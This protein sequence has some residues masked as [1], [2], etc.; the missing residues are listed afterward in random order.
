MELCTCEKAVFFLPVNL[1]EG[2]NETVPLCRHVYFSIGA[3]CGILKSYS[4]HVL[5]Q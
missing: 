2:T 1:H 5:L 3:S 4:T